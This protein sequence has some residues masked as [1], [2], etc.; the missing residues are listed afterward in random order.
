MKENLKMAET[1]VECDDGT[2]VSALF[3][4]IGMNPSLQG[5]D[6]LKNAVLVYKKNKGAM[7]SICKEVA[8]K[9]NVAVVKVERS[10]RFAVNYVQDQGNLKRLNGILG[11]EYVKQG[12][13]ISTKEFIA[14]IAEFVNNDYFRNEILI[15]NL[16]NL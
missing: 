8:E 10:I 9:N 2:I 15:K 13:T 4:E 1:G 12:I 16:K 11:I 6:Y 3:M 7:K 14:L 5:F